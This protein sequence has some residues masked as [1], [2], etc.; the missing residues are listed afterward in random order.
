MKKY[1]YLKGTG[2]VVGRK[3]I[4]SGRLRSSFFLSSSCV[5]IGIKT[6]TYEATE[7]A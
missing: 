7:E 6:A 3:Y 5:K 1:P 2:G 4:I